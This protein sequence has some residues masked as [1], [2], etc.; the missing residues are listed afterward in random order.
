MSDTLP[1]AG[2]IQQGAGSLNVDGAVRLAK[3]LRTDIASAI[4][5]GTIQPGDN[6]LASGQTVP[7]PVSIIQ[8]Q[9]VKWGQIVFAGGS[10]LVS[11]WALFANYQG[12]YDP[13][14]VWVRDWV[15]L[16]TPVDSPSTT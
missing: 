11:G 3:A 4:A 14:L 10:H 6:L 2:L 13:R 16:Y 7:I 9:V 5:A 8:G 1:G 12:F 15:R